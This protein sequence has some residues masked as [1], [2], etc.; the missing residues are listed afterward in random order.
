[1]IRLRGV[2]KRAVYG[3]GLT[4][5]GVGIMVTKACKSALLILL[6]AAAA[7]AQDDR[8]EPIKLR[9]DLVTVTA[10]VRDQ[11]NRP[12]R[13][14]KAADFTIYED[15]VRQKIDHF[16]TAEVPFALMLLLDISGSTSD[17][18]E[19]I[20]R[21]AK[22]FV[23]R[24]RPDDRVGVIVFS[25]EVEMISEFD[26]GRARV[27]AA[28]DSIAP[29]AGPGDYRFTSKTGTSFYDALFLA[30]ED[31]PLGKIEGRK[32]IVCLSDGV[33]SKSRLAYKDIS[34]LV[35]K[36]EASFYFLNLNTEQATLEGLLKPR[37]DPGYVNFSQSQ[38]DR[39]YAA[40]DPDSPERFRPR[41]VMSPLV[42]REINA[43]LYENALREEREM[44]ERTGG[45][46]Y[47]VN[48]LTDLGAVY[49]QVADELRSQY[50][51]SYYPINEARDGRWR[52]I[53]VDVRHPGATVRARSGYRAPGN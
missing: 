51:I 38:V 47:P 12:V 21:A 3:L 16:A 10:S 15:G 25:G 29:A 20:K 24:L 19:L 33:D 53:R 42:K 17:D 5:P 2:G 39:Y 52:Q 7:R 37:T 11:G 28:I 36:S 45:R 50:S 26:D 46:V 41:E 8:D 40:V 35:E 4:V 32:A 43:W 22:G 9:A 31:S 27:E 1:M 6:L 14:L 23:A 48:A 49:K 18:I 44:A 30:I 13:S 34:P